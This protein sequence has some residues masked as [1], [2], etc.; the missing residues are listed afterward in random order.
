MEHYKQSGSIDI[1][2]CLRVYVLNLQARGRIISNNGPAGV[3]G[4]PG[5]PQIRSLKMRSSVFVSIPTPTSPHPSTLCYTVWPCL[6]P[7]RLSNASCSSLCR[8]TTKAAP[9]GGPKGL[10]PLSPKGRRGP[11]PAKGFEESRHQ[12]Q[13]SSVPGATG[14]GRSMGGHGW[15]G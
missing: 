14:V 10:L 5:T 12:Q 1:L 2:L 8:P 6:L 11:G 9:A 7:C 15:C 13:P 3:L 4:L